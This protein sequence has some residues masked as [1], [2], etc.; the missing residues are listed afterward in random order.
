MK[1]PKGRKHMSAHRRTV[2]QAGAAAA[3]GVIPFSSVHAQSNKSIKIGVLTDMSGPYRDLNGPVSVACA[4]LAVQ[5]F[6]PRGF[7]TEIVVADHQ[8]KPDVALNIARQWFDRE[9]VDMVLNLAAS[10][11][12]L[13]LAELAREEQGCHC[14][15]YGDIGSNWASLHT[16]YYPLGLRHLHARKVHWSGHGPRGW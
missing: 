11:V 2:L 3:A 6:G 5:E 12:A 13:A 8:N 9:G 4:R 16:K 1:L 15:L 10:S 14:Y 7:E